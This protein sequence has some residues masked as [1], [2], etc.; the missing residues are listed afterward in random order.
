MTTICFEEHQSFRQPWLWVLMLAT[1]AV[2]LVASSLAPEGQTVPW[3]VLA[4]R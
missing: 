3:V 2:L 4:A 1:L